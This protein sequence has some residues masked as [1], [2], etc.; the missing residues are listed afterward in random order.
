MKMKFSKEIKY[1]YNC[2]IIKSR[3][4]EGKDITY[5]THSLSQKLEYL[6]SERL[7]STA[8]FIAERW[9]LNF[10]EDIVIVKHVACH[11]NGNVDTHI[12]KWY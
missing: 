9:N 6:W 8:G 10:F 2:F 12:E 7:V 4:T 5:S 1:S 3:I 11:P